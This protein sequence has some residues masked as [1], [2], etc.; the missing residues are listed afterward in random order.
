M[1][2][3]SAIR[4]VAMPA[5]ENKVRIG[6]RGSS[7]ILKS[8]FTSGLPVAGR[9][10]IDK[11]VLL[12]VQGLGQQGNKGVSEVGTVTGGKGLRAPEE[13]SGDASV[14]D[15]SSSLLPFH[16]GVIHYFVAMLPLPPPQLVEMV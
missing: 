8:L 13:L 9:D 2:I 12:V 4:K 15:G 1:R 3:G 7:G 10:D 5:E 16:I 6:T 11:P 14:E